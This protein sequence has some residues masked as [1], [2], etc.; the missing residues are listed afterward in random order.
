M[1]TYHETLYNAVMA[2]LEENKAKFS[3]QTTLWEDYG[4]QPMSY[5]T[6]Q[7]KM[8]QGINSKGKECA[9]HVTIYR[10]PSGRYEVTAYPTR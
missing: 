6:S 1:T 4:F 7:T 10:M 2:G 5:E 9:L 8:I 3:P